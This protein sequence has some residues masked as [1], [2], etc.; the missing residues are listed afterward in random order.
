MAR[1]AFLYLRIEITTERGLVRTENM[2]TNKWHSKIY[3]KTS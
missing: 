2:E 1:Y 3:S